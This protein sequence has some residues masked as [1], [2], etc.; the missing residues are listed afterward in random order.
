MR[1]RITELVKFLKVQ[2]DRTKGSN[3]MLTMGED[4]NYENSLIWYE[5]MEKMASSLLAL[6]ASGKIDVAS[7]LAPR[8]DK[9]NIFYSS[10]NTYTDCKFKEIRAAQKLDGPYETKTDDFF[11]YSDRPNGFLDRIFHIAS[12]SQTPRTGWLIFPFGSKTNS[13]TVRS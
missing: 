11:P 12:S 2:S 5:N 13:G 10:P 3:I 4:F 7:I 1:A 8:F 9:I 6:Q